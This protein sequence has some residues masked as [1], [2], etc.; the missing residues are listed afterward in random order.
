VLA[1][2]GAEEIVE[3]LCPVRRHDDVVRD[4]VTLQRAQRQGDV[5][6]VV[7]HQQDLSRVHKCLQTRG[8]RAVT[9]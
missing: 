3:R 2:V 5:V 6:R 7:F 8:E 1:A 9:E 4:V